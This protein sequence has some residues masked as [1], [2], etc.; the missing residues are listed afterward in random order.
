MPQNQQPRESINQSPTPAPLPK[1][2]D[3]DDQNRQGR[4]E[5]FH[6]GNVQHQLSDAITRA[7][8]KYAQPSKFD[9]SQ[10]PSNNPVQPV[11]HQTPVGAAT[12]KIRLAT[13]PSTNTIPRQTRSANA[14]ASLSVPPMDQNTL[15]ST[16]GTVGSGLRNNSEHNGI[17]RV[18][19]EQ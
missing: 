11:Q 17:R 1:P 4:L 18:N 9:A 15:R 19:Y 14:T 7:S 10:I 5:R 8:Q 12:A 16:R 13:P 6:Y 2:N 3:Q